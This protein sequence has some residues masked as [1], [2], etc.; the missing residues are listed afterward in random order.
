M[1]LTYLRRPIHDLGFET[2]ALPVLAEPS[3]RQ[4]KHFVQHGHTST[5]EH[6]VNVAYLCY[7]VGKRLGMDVP[8]LV[9][10]SLL[11]DMYLYDWHDDIPEEIDQLGKH[12]FYHPKV[13]CQNAHR[14]FR[15]TPMERDIIMRHMWPVTVILPK[16]RESWLLVFVDKYCACME[17]FLEKRIR[18]DKFLRHR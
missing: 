7:R 2:L 9:R 17:F 18:I 12:A 14:I 5:L 15:L 13:A 10:A 6:C 4:M 3:V 11:H 8:K 16:Y 1:L